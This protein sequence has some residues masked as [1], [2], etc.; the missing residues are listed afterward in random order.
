[1]GIPARA[2]VVVS[3]IDVDLLLSEVHK[4]R[5]EMCAEHVGLDDSF[6]LSGPGMASGDDMPIGDEMVLCAA[7]PYEGSRG[8]KWFAIGALFDWNGGQG[9]NVDLGHR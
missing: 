7:L 4:A 5:V 8:A 1:M 9:E 2:V 6:K 3:D